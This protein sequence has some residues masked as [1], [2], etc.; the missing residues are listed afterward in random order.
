VRAHV[1]EL[2][3]SLGEKYDNAELRSVSEA[4]VE[5][6]GYANKYYD[7]Q[8][9]WIQAKEEDL[10]AFGNT[11]ASCLYL[12]ANMANLFAPIIPEGCEKLAKVLQMGELSWNEVTL[13]ETFEIGELPILYARIDG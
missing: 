12:M 8:K 11:T 2:Y 5:L 10:T 6:I 13:P 9:P 1:Q 7:D 3:K 4:M